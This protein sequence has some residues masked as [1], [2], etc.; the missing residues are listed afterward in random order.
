MF[1]SQGPTGTV[2]PSAFPY[3]WEIKFDLIYG[4]NHTP[5]SPRL[6]ANLLPL[7]ATTVDSA[8]VKQ[9]FSPNWTEFQY[10]L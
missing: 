7:L 2:R 8:K 1:N 5:S 9:V 10:F 6:E 4:F 3:L